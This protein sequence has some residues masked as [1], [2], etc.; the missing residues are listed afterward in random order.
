M[1]A[2]LGVAAQVGVAARTVPAK[3]LPGAGALDGSARSEAPVWS[4]PAANA[5]PRHQCAVHWVGAAARCRP[6]FA[7][8]GGT[9]W[10]RCSLD[11][12]PFR[13]S[14]RPAEGCDARS[15]RTWAAK[16]SARDT[17]S[18]GVPWR[19]SSARQMG[20]STPR[21]AAIPSDLHLRRFLH[22]QRLT[23]YAERK[24]RGP[25]SMR[26]ADCSGSASS[27]STRMGSGVRLREP[28]RLRGENCRGRIGLENR[29]AKGGTPFR[30]ETQ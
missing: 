16:A 13:R 26:T 1:E 30:P 12:R 22:W 21:G 7:S 5:D 27:G 8:E 20:N 4:A 18:I 14:R 3:E 28:V 6:N 15:C 29:S 25:E 10:R 2:R 17:R 23:R 9:T 24:R 11:W 19:H